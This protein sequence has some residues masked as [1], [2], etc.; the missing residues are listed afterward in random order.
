MFIWNETPRRRAR[1]EII[2]MIDVMMF[3]LVFF[4]LI[5]LHVIPAIGIKTDLPGSGQTDKLEVR[6]HVLVTISANGRLQLDG[7]DY[8]LEGVRS[9]LAAI[10]KTNPNADVV[11]NSDKEASVQFVIDVMDAIKSA[12]INAIA[13]AAK[14]K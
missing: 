11:I 14:P 2:P 7:E 12:G 10:Q 8:T 9:A 1:I 13:I 3:L 4:V 5:S 6:K